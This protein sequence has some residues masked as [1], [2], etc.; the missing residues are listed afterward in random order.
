M[1]K[2]Y[3]HEIAIPL[4]KQ[5]K[6]GD[7]FLAQAQPV[8]LKDPKKKD[9]KVKPKGKDNE[10]KPALPAKGVINPN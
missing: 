10:K 3:K 9:P 5:V 8:A 6:L 7:D 4:E 2:N 1:S